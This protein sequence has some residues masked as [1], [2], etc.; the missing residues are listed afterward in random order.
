MP[1]NSKGK[2]EGIWHRI[3][4][5]RDAYVKKKKCKTWVRLDTLVCLRIGPGYNHLEN[6]SYMVTIGVHYMVYG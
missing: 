3:L 2:K 4:A 6:S 5:R 1:Q